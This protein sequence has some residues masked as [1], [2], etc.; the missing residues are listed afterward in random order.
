MWFGISCDQVLLK[1]LQF[2]IK[3]SLLFFFDIYRLYLI[4]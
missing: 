3:Q 2:K 4:Y 1:G